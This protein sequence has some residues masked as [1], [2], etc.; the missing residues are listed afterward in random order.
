M[1]NKHL[2][3]ADVA[4]YMFSFLAV[5]CIAMSI[6]YFYIGEDM[7]M[8]VSSLMNCILLIILLKRDKKDI[9]DSIQHDS[10]RVSTKL[11]HQKT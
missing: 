7:R 11:P 1:K 10:T 2:I 3:L 8:I 6:Y 4:V 9:C 5:V